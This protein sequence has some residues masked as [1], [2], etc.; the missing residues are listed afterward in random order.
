MRNGQLAELKHKKYVCA[1]ALV[2]EREC[3]CVCVVV[4]MLGHGCVRECVCVR[5]CVCPAGKDGDLITKLN[6]LLL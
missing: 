2:V 1:R 3:V 5:A 4:R 6:K